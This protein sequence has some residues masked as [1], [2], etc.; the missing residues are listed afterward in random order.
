MLAKCYMENEGEEWNYL[1]LGGENKGE[2]KE[3]E[4]L[5]GRRSGSNR[6][7]AQDECN[8]G[9]WLKKMNIPLG[10]GGGG[11]IMPREGRRVT[12]NRLPRSHNEIPSCS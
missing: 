6:R 9:A 8:G 7:R 3:I 11:G 5:Q 1:G 10:G 2:Q 4:G 12:V